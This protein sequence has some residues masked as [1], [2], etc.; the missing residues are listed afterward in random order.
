MSWRLAFGEFELDEARFELRRAG[1][2]VAVQPKVL[3]LIFYLAR[4]RARVVGK[5]ELFDKVWNG[6]VV[7]EA[8][9]SQ[10]VS[11]ARRALG[12][13]P[14]EQHTLRTVR[15]KGLQFVAQVQARRAVKA[16]PLVGS[17]MLE[18]AQEA[19]R[20]ASEEFSAPY[21]FIVLHC[22][23]PGDGGASW[24][25]AEVD[26]VV[27]VRGSARRSE[28]KP[29]MTRELRITVPGLAMSRTH[30]RIVRTPNE[31]L[32][33]DEKSRNGTFV[34]GERIE[35]RALE[36][37][38]LVEC[39]RT[40]FRFSLERGSSSDE[41][42]G[43]LLTT[44]TPALL[45]LERDLQRIATSDLPVLILGESGAGKTHLAQALH[46]ASGRRGPLVAVEASAVDRDALE[47]ARHGTLLLESLERIP[48]AT[49]LTS[50][51]ESAKDLRT[52]A[53]S[54][55]PLAEL[56]ERLPRELLTR[57]AGYRCALPPLRERIGDLGALVA[58]MLHEPPIID[59]A[60][61]QKLLRH[62]WPG[63][64]RELAHALKAASTLAHDRIGAEHVQ[65]VKS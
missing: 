39:G 40:L 12:D 24:S 28:R 5:D 50:A 30:A 41:D 10:A 32:V 3:D 53:T 22:D 6:V 29:G 61:G 14:E 37:G 27:V 35:R 19:P 38:D 55:A 49:A 63:N 25:L 44:V 15:G 4:H 56:E 23:S 43:E 54:I 7:T 18:T 47:R 60:A 52:V 65:L 48:N 1:T 33:V 16:Q 45:A 13:T 34:N 62:R 20:R 36:E 64:L 31:W 51:L 9:L 42:V 2:P 59:V 17:T 8:S 11:L 58:A 46:R 26:E 21:L 57:L